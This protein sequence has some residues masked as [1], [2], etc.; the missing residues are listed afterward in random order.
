MKINMTD[1]YRTKA[2]DDVEIKF[3]DGRGDYPV[4]GYVLDDNP[5]CGGTTSWTV[6]GEQ[7]INNKNNSLSLV[8]VEVW[9]DLKI[10]DIVMINFDNRGTYIPR[11][12]AG[13]GEFFIDGKSSMTKI[14]SGSN[15]SLRNLIWKLPEV[16][17]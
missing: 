11:H 1:K 7:N 16:K 15:Y 13:K 4:V 17:S 9:E 14:N 2:G 12:Y 8:K 5:F 10:D 6:C 3:V